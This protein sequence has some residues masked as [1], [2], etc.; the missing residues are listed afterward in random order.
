MSRFFMRQTKASGSTKR[1]IERIMRLGE[2]GARR[3]LHSAKRR[4]YLER[5]GYAE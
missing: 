5:V 2:R 3:A 1:R 4:E